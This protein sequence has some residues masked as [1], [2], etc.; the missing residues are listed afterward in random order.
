MFNLGFSEVLAIGV[1][2]LLVIGP[3][4]LPEV[5]RV[6]GRLLGEL[7]KATQDLSGGLLEVKRDVE[8]SIHDVKNDLVK[9][10]L[11]LKDSVL[12]IDD[13][14]TA[15]PVEQPNNESSDIA[16]DDSSQEKLDDK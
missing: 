8:G 9:E 7:R 16:L 3:K 6:I 11:K 1:I 12:N 10:S 14:M 5:A 15:E 13:G 4:Q 2:A